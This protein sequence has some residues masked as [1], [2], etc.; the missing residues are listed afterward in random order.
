M[1]ASRQE[2]FCQRHIV[3]IGWS[4]PNAGDDSRRSTRDEQ[5][6]PAVATDAAAPSFAHHSCQVW[7]LLKFHSIF[8]FFF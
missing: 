8:L 1:M 4:K 5:V 6:K 3:G 7:I 2:G